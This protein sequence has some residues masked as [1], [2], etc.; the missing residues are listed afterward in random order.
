MHWSTRYL[1]G[2]LGSAL[3]T[4]GGAVALPYGAYRAAK[5]GANYL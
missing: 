2:P 5:Y 3:G 1:L 4:M